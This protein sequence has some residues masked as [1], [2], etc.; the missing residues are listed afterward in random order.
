M[1]GIITCDAVVVRMVEA[2][3][4]NAAVCFTVASTVV[5]VCSISVLL[6]LLLLCFIGAC[7]S[8]RVCHG[9]FL[10]L[11]LL[12]LVILTVCVATTTAAQ[13]KIMFVVALVVVK[14]CCFVVA[15]VSVSVVSWR[16][17][18]AHG[19]K[20]FADFLEKVK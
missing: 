10:L 5:A 2:F 17:D 13:V 19:R 7:R 8:Q 14:G 20:T 12:M 6:L 1:F 4:V 9:L 11:L 3:N 18:C 16:S 15:V